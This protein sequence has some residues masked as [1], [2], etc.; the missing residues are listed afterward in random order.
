MFEHLQRVQDQVKKLAV[1]MRRKKRSQA[2]H[3]GE[4]KAHEALYFSHILRSVCFSVNKLF[5]L[6]LLPPLS[7]RVVFAE[8]LVKLETS[9]TVSF[10]IYITHGS[11][12]CSQRLFDI[13]GGIYH[14]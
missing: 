5:Y 3:G 2:I 9:N 6:F 12:N 8:S 11:L 7:Y 14:V 1:E 10:C 4:N 13:K